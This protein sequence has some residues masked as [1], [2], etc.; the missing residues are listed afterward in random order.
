MITAL[1]II[2]CRV[3]CEVGEIFVGRA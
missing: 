1:S 2:I 3:S